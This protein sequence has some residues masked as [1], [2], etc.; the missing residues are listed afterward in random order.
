VIKRGPDVLWRATG[1]LLVLGRP[2]GTVITVTG[3]GADVWQLLGTTPLEQLV[4][5]LAAQYGASAPVVRADV[6]ALL[7][8]LRL[9]GFVVDG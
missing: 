2:D 4:A 5:D 9:Q 6:Q 7:A 8:Q 1:Q 3:P